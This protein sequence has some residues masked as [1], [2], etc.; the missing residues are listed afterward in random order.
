MDDVDCTG[1]EESI[2]DCP[3]SGWGNVHT[4]CTHSNDAGVICTAIPENEY[5]AR[6]KGGAND[7][8]GRVEIYYSNQWGSIC[9]D[10]WT[11]K[12][13]MVVCHSLGG[14]GVSE[15][16]TTRYVCL[17]PS[18]PKWYLCH[19]YVIR[20]GK[21][22]GQI[23][24]DDVNCTG[25]ENFIY[26]CQHPDFGANNCGHGEDVGVVCKRMCDLK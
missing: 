14:S 8:E 18:D 10:H 15:Y 4:A 25:I 6:L 2:L 17:L 20:F 1:T 11:M 13:A 19:N 24:L 9:D 3:H 21:G 23:W 12:E 22:T 26:E 7:Y 5:P 16:M